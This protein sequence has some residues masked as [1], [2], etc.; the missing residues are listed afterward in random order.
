M[1]SEAAAN[2]VLERVKGDLASSKPD[3]LLQISLDIPQAV[4]TVF[5][6]LPAVKALREQIVKELPT[7]DVVRFDTLE[8]HT[9]VLSATHA[10][11]L[12][13]TQPNRGTTSRSRAAVGSAARCIPRRRSRYA[14]A[15]WWRIRRE[16]RGLRAP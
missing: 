5:G 1:N 7:F 2:A 11:F 10:K 14:E 6:V 8:D 15:R 3:E 16:G 4:A 13:A 12:S 9:L